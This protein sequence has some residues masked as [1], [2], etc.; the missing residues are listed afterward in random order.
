M[1]KLVVLF[2]AILFLAACSSTRFAYRNADWFINWA[3]DDFVELDSQ[4]QSRF[5]DSLHNMLDWHCVKELPRYRQYLDD[6][7]GVLVE[8]SPLVLTEA[9]L[10]SLSVR[11]V[12]AWSVLVARAFA[13]SHPIVESFSDSQVSD[14]LLELEDRNQRLYKKY[15][16]IDAQALEEIRVQRVR[17]AMRRW[18]GS[19]SK[20]QKQLALAWAQR[21]D[22]VYDLMHERR[23]KW[24]SRLADILAQRAEVGFVAAL[25]EHLLHPERLYTLAQRQRLLANQ[26]SAQQ[27]LL[28]LERSLSQRQRR[29]LLAELSGIVEDIERLSA[30]NCRL[31]EN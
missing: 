9:A 27:L 23:E 17:D 19:V 4:Q 30:P 12:E 6:L 21:A 29:H 8:D 24:R 22:N 28:A 20:E 3:V 31:R 18:A 25:R 15:G 13:E 5:D 7:T 26:Q 14:L 10:Q 16:A 11:A 1:R 2:A